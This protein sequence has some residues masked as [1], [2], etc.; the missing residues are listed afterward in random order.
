MDITKNVALNYLYCRSNQLTSLDVTKNV[1]LTTLDLADNQLTTLNVTNNVALTTLCCSTNQLTS[2]DLS[3]NPKLEYL[4]APYNT[5]KI[6]TVYYIVNDKKSYTYDLN[7]TEV[8]NSLTADGFDFA[9]ASNFI[10]ATVNSKNILTFDDDKIKATYDYSTGFTGSTEEYKSFISTLTYDPSE[11]VA[12]VEGISVDS[13][14]IY[15]TEGAVNVV[16]PTSVKVDIYTLTGTIVYTGIGTTI[17]L[18]AG[19]Y[20]ATTGTYRTKVIVK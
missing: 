3:K 19:I 18:P 1:A 8:G 11:A 4:Y 20:M 9:K 12:S 14:I 15:G 16:A 5:R 7:T 10:N 2:L 17:T 13:I 6:K